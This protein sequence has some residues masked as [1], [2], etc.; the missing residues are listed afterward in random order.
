MIFTGKNLPI[1]ELS[2][3]LNLLCRGYNQASRR[4]NM[5]AGNIE[6]KKQFMSILLKGTAF[7]RLLV[8]NIAL[9][10]SVL[11][12]IDCTIDKNWFSEA[13]QQE[14]EKFARWADMRHTVFELIKGS[15][16]PGYMKIVLS[17]LPRQPRK[18]IKTRRPFLLTF[19]LK[20][21]F[22]PLLP[23]APKKCLPWIRPLKE[24]GTNTRQNFLKTTE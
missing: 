20:T 13:E 17:P 3:G 5:I 7:D 1:Q 4:T 9:R 6:N 15:K 11:F 18:Y 24:H 8:R 12:E 19:F 22:S 10:T 21:I 16:L 14:L 23:E 2:R